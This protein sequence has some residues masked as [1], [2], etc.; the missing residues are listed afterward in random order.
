MTVR[1]REEAYIQKQWRKA[2]GGD[3]FAMQ[4][5]AAAYRILGKTRLAFRWFKKAAHGRGHQYL[6][7]S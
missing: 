3:Y 2:M 4:N 1:E 6:C 5:I 7:P